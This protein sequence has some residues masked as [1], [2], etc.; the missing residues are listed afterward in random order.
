MGLFFAVSM[1]A[2]AVIPA[3]VLATAVAVAWVMD[4]FRR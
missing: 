4:G 2:P 3:A 1:T